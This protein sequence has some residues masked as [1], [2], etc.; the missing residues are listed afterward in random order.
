[1]TKTGESRFEKVRSIKVEE[2][3]RFNIIQTLCELFE[4]WAKFEIEHDE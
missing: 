2:S 1:M 4:C 3:N